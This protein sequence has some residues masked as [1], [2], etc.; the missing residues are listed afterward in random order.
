[1]LNTGASRFRTLLSN[2]ETV[3][4]IMEDSGPGIDQAVKHSVCLRAAQNRRPT[5]VAVSSVCSLVPIGRRKIAFRSMSIC[6]AGS[7]T[8][9]FLLRVLNWRTP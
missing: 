4:V 5:E 6:I 2:A 8:P 7:P 1:M 3:S 9:D